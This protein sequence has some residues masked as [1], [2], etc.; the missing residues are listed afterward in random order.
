MFNSHH[1]LANFMTGEV[2]R[3]LARRASCTP[4]LSTEIA[5]K[6]AEMK[7]DRYLRILEDC[8]C[9]KCEKARTW[10]RDRLQIVGKQVT[11]DVAAYYNERNRPELCGRSQLRL[12]DLYAR[13]SGMSRSNL[14]RAI[15]FSRSL[16]T[17]EGPSVT[18]APQSRVVESCVKYLKEAAE[19]C[20]RRL[21][22]ELPSFSQLEHIR[23]PGSLLQI[24]KTQ[25]R[26]FDGDGIEIP[27]SL[28]SELA[29]MN[30]LALSDDVVRYESEGREL[31][32]CRFA[33]V[34]CAEIAEVYSVLTRVDEDRWK[35]VS[36]IEAGLMGLRYLRHLVYRARKL[37]ISLPLNQSLA[38]LTSY[39]TAAHG[40]AYIDIWCEDATEDRPGPNSVSIEL[41][42]NGIAFVD[43]RYDSPIAAL[44]AEEAARKNGRGLFRLLPAIATAPDS[45]LMP[46]RRRDDE[47]RRDLPID[48]TT[49]V[50]L[51]ECHDHTVERFLY[52]A[53]SSAPG[54]ND[55]LFLCGRKYPIPKDRY[56]CIYSNV[57]VPKEEAES[58]QEE[59][60]YLV[61]V[62]SGAHHTTYDGEVFDSL[63]CNYGRF[64]NDLGLQETVDYAVQQADSSK[65]G[66]FSKKDV[67][68]VSRRMANCVF[69]E[70]RGT[71]GKK[72]LTLAA[73]REI[74]A[75][76]APL[77]LS[78]CYGFFS[79]WTVAVCR[80]PNR[81]PSKI[82]DPILWLLQSRFSVLNDEQ[83]RQFSNG[84]W[85]PHHGLT[86]LSP[87]VGEKYRAAK[88]PPG[89]N[90]RDFQ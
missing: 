37:F 48:E 71:D 8:D 41:L 89:L 49:A 50:R 20:P 22:T 38:K 19:K 1:A 80:A 16:A 85:Q 45:P 6:A 14:D 33:C 54:G 55:G 23:P 9:S 5:Q 47:Q 26:C 78:V 13:F 72:Q 67:E 11:G 69:K 65:Y 18:S 74:P 21:A 31:V 46:W 36:T 30:G 2:G 32:R 53:P 3:L 35:T 60:D 52:V 61:T 81:L 34:D 70:E 10:E 88:V 39:P 59:R 24:E 28:L 44:A 82:S 75:G 15:K 25:I 63:L 76:D 7:Y 29:A 27:L 84:V 40:R 73:S 64:A 43:V 87:D 57:V 62:Q 90:T 58:L 86:T 79:Y 51:Y 17:G 12:D 83:R 4:R 56:L 42:L 77:E 68:D 66:Y